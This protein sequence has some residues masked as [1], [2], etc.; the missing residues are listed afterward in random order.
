MYLVSILPTV[1]E[2]A[3]MHNAYHMEEI[4]YYTSIGHNPGNDIG[5]RLGSSFERELLTPAISVTKDVVVASSRT[6]TERK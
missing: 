3:T 1:P 6:Q 4:D 5:T 2:L